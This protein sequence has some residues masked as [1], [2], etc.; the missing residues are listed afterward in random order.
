M[1]LMTAIFEAV[2]VQPG[3]NAGNSER[4]SS[5]RTDE[6][7][8]KDLANDRGFLILDLQ[9]FFALA[10][11]A[12]GFVGIVTQRWSLTVPKPQ[13]RILNHRPTHVFG[14]LFRI[15]LVETRENSDC[16]L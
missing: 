13:G 8:I 12:I 5:F 10:S 7:E 4:R 1:K 6:V 9:L 14:G 16:E 2:F 15:I 11:D 3:S